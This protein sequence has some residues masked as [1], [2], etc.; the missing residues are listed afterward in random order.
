MSCSVRC[1]S[2]RSIGPSVRSGRRRSSRADQLLRRQELDPR[3]GQL[4]RQRQAVEPAA[5]RRHVR[6]VAGGDRERRLDGA[7]PLDEEAHRLDLE[8]RRRAAASGSGSG[9][10]SG[11]TGNS[12]SPETRSAARL[13][14]STFR[15]R[16]GGQQRRHR[17][18]PPPAGAAPR[19]PGRAGTTPSAG[20]RSGAGS[21]PRCGARASPSA[22][23][24]APGIA[25]GSAIAASGTKTT[26][27]AN[28]TSRATAS[29]RRVLPPPPGPVRVSKRVSGRSRIARA[30]LDLCPPAD[31]RRQRHRQRGGAH[32]GPRRKHRAR[33]RQL[34]MVTAGLRDRQA[35]PEPRI[36][37]RPEDATPAP[38][39]RAASPAPGR[40]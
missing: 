31:Q 7:R 22:L 39:G 3:R 1:R 40:C 14:A 32:D 12:R 17:R 29:A 18:P 30:R 37:R 23:A 10:P 28:A 33:D 20:G 11:G 8:Q 15:C 35:Y 38:P 2:G 25:A 13:V 24:I 5:D 4:D 34:S 27:S 21:A 6:H 16:A 9:R 26:P 36:R 19:C